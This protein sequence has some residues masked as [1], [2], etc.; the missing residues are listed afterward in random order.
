VSFFR[1][2]DRVLIAGDAFI[3][4]K[5]ES[6]WG[7]MTRHQRVHGPPMYFTQDWERARDSVRKLAKLN[8]AVAAT[9]HG[10]P[11]HNPRLDHELNEL[12]RHFDQ[13]AVPA[14]GRYVRRPAIADERGTMSVPPPVPDP[15]PKVAAVVA[16]A[17]VGF[18]VAAYLK[19]RSERWD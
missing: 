1:D 16:A 5:Q 13:L 2:S 14:D 6:F 15:W 9:G 7:V 10:V 18:G 19:R 17:A 12:A 8:P 11:M 3:T 4:Q